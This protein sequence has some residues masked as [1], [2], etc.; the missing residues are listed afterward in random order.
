MYILASLVIL[1]L[2]IDCQF[3]P[4]QQIVDLKKY[5][6]IMLN[7]LKEKEKHHRRKLSSGIDYINPTSILNIYEDC[8]I[9][10]FS[11]KMKANMDTTT[12][13]F[14]ILY[15]NTT[16]IS[17]QFEIKDA[18]GNTVPLNNT[19]NCTIDDGNYLTINARLLSGYELSLQIK[20]KHALD[21]LDTNKNFLYK[22]IIQKKN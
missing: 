3:D 11:I 10:D 22:K 16:I 12:P 20:M 17:Y 8:M 21:N 7:E 4:N 2:T 5:D 15:K 14:S 13:D 18:N 19:Y 6:E 9:E 1:F